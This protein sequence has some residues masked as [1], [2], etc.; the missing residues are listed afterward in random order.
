[1]ISIDIAIE[2]YDR[3]PFG[4]G[5]GSDGTVYFPK[6]TFRISPKISLRCRMHWEARIGQAG[7][8]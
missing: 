2:I 3:N 5:Q 6:K 4:V 7:G 8:H 1:M